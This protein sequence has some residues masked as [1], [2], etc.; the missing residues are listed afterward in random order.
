[1]I[2]NIFKVLPDDTSVNDNLAPSLLPPKGR[3]LV[4]IAIYSSPSGGGV[5]GGLNSHLSTMHLLDE[6]GSSDIPKRIILY[7]GED[8]PLLKIG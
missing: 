3:F 5:E 8:Y 1:M 4:T 2:E 6:H 7:G